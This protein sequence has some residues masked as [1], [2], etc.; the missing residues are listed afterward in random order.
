VI[1]VAGITLNEFNWIQLISLI[2]LLS[3]LAIS[4]LGLFR[5]ARNTRSPRRT[6]LI[7]LNLVAFLG[8]SGLILQP[9][10]EYSGD[11]SEAGKVRLISSPIDGEL[12]DSEFETF[13]LESS[14]NRPNITLIKTPE[15]LLLDNP[16][17]R[18]IEVIGNG[19]S[20]R[21]WRSF[22]N[23][24]IDYQKPKLI[25]GF[26][27]VSWNKQLNI[28]ES[29]R[30]SGRF[31][32]EEKGLLVIQLL[33]PAGDIVDEKLMRSGEYSSLAA[34]PKLAGLHEYKV[35]VRN[36]KKEIILREAIHFQVRNQ[37]NAKLLVIQS[38]PSFETKQLQNWA[39]ENGAEILVK[40]KISRNKFISRATNLT[41]L[42]EEK[43]SPKLFEYFDM[44]IMDGRG[45]TELS[46][47]ELEWLSLAVKNGLGLLVL[48]DQTLLNNQSNKLANLLAGVQLKFL[49]SSD[50]V[51]P[52]WADNN[53]IYH[54]VSE[55]F[56]PRTAISVEVNTNQLINLRRLV[57]SEKNELLVHQ[58]SFG[59]GNIVLSS[60]RSTHQWMTS[61]NKNIFSEYWKNIIT[62]IARTE[63]I[64]VEYSRSNSEIKFVGVLAMEC[65]DS[66][67]QFDSIRLKHVQDTSIR[68]ELLLQNTQMSQYKKCG[69]YWPKRSGWHQIFYNINNQASESTDWTYVES[70]NNWLAL[71]QAQ[72]IKATLAKLSMN[73]RNQS[74][75]PGNSYK[76]ISL[77]FFWWMFFISASLIWF[78]GKFD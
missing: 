49:K 3:T 65:I 66:Q 62:N 38:S 22:E 41:D 8:L 77:W 48:V 10:Y 47:I 26:V 2:A 35:E 33:D 70:A 1:E 5:R 53:G 71:Q 45:L 75:G 37:S 14:V 31:Q 59:M 15:H 24:K 6:V 40:T 9:Q 25:Q 7:I 60:L 29:V 64:S 44:L 17:L 67:T 23:I 68:Q 54:A 55:E 11:A 61:G 43:L 19:L 76:P 63:Q 34:K 73:N 32:T 52:Y 12:P 21:S 46:A 28:G 39:A 36:D 27:D 30:F 18:Q 13:S 57:E 72:N 74:S 69:Y 20:E 58:H 16:N 78:E 50:D 56:I 4:L 51:V 42:E